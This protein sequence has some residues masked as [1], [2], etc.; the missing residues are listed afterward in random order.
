MPAQ[1]SVQTQDFNLAAEYELVRQSN[2][3]IGGIAC[4]SGLVRDVYSSDEVAGSIQCLE[5]EH[6]PGMTEKALQKIADCAVTRWHL[7]ACRVIHRV[8]KLSPSDQIVMVMTAA[9]HRQEAFESAEYIMDYLKSRAPFWKK[10]WDKSGSEW[11]A[12]R[13]SDEEALVR[14]QQSAALEDS[15]S[16]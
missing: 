5:L 8:G 12:T 10:Q 13:S 16:P 3:S 6:Y 2:A 7:L 11:V 1:I 4:F 9:T 15:N 14:W